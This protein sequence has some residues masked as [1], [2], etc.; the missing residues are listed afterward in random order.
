MSAGTTESNHGSMGSNR[1]FLSI[2]VM[3]TVTTTARYYSLLIQFRRFDCNLW[4]GLDD[5]F[6]VKWDHC[7]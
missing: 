2:Y 3:H 4:K 5:K 7:C 1:W 6:T